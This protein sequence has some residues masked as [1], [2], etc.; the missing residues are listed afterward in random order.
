MQAS[1]YVGK[2]FGKL[3]VLSVLYKKADHYKMICVCDC[4]NFSTPWLASL[5]QGRSKSC[6]CTIQSAILKATTKH[7]HSTK[8]LKSLSY[9]SWCA[10]VQRCTNTKL[11]SYK[12]YGGAGIAVCDRWL[13]FANFLED[14]GERKPGQTI[15]R[16]DGSKGYFK[17]NCR[18]ADIQTQNLNTKKR[19]DAIHSKYKGVCRAGSKWSVTLKG[20]HI[21][22]FDNEIDAA[23]A[24]DAVAKNYLGSVLNFPDIETPPAD[25]YSFRKP[26]G[27]KLTQQL[28]DE[29]KASNLT[30]KELV[31]IYGVC[32]STINGIKAGRIWS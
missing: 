11:E 9:S 27:V 23:I 19:S 8:A 14:M 12:K 10:M 5:K 24:Y 21:G 15:D 1:D 28:A 29:I 31:D 2:R 17:E 30:T 16:I 25:I 22:V 13:T 6:K 32:K 18:W 7:G 20:I 4:G 26:R 3:T